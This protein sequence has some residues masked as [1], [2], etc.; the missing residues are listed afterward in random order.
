M[1]QTP[2]GS[3]H[4]LPD[5]FTP[6]MFRTTADKVTI[7][8]HLDDCAGDNAPLLVVPGSH[9]LGRVPSAQAAEVARELGQVACLADAGDLWVYATSIVH[10]SERAQHPRRRRVLHV[11]YA[12]TPLP[13]GL[14]WLGV[15]EG[16]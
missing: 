2:D 8:A 10:A 6:L 5:V 9:R 14:D 4:A 1:G 16:R 11:D 13:A 12:N 7:R 15:A 3:R